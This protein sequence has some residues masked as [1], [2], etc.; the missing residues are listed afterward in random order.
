MPY[1]TID[2]V[3]ARYKPIRTM[4][5]SS[6]LQVT[7]VDVAS[8]FIEDA[9]NY[10]D[11]FLAI[12][13]EVPLPDS[14]LVR[15]CAA[16]LAIFN[17]MVEKLPE[18]PDFMQ[19]RYDRWHKMLEDLRDG[20][21]ILPGSATTVSTGDQEAWSNNEDYHSIFSPVLDPLDQA[22]DK[23]WVESAKNVRDD[24]Y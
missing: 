20:D 22:V 15:Q 18:V 13:Y 24:D 4:I 23:D 6:D 14:A 11:A 2:D 5:G 1:A 10:I 8:I 3:F 9:E 17:M 16:D 21:L 12:R 19:A 7:S